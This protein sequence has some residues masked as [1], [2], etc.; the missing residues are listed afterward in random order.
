VVNLPQQSKHAPGIFAVVIVFFK[1]WRATVTKATNA[2]CAVVTECFLI[3][4]F[5]F[6][7]LY[8][9]I[10]F[11]SSFCF[12]FSY[13]ILYFYFSF[14]FPFLSLYFFFLIFLVSI[15]LFLFFLCFLFYLFI[16]HLLLIFFLVL[17]ILLLFI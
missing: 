1:S 10:N 8:S 9:L 5:L 6:P 4:L 12:F 2:H 11:L 17:L 14:L 13:I 15:I 3:L 7:S 16:Y